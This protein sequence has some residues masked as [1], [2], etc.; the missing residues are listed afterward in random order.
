M[1]LH[2][3]TKQVL[4]SEPLTGDALKLIR[5]I[6]STYI[7]NDKDLFMSIKVS[8]IYR[9]L[10][11]EDSEEAFSYIQQLFTEINEPVMVRDFKYRAKIYPM[12]FLF[13][14]DYSFDG[15]DIEIEINEE[16]LHA[17]K[18]YMIS[19]FLSS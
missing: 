5:A 17:E 19:P 16:F 2:Q 11:L 7:N 8:A 10:R 14:C 3:V 13:F 4:F 6:Y 15:E 9:V 18:E 12:R 1:S